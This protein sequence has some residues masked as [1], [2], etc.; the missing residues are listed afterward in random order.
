[1]LKGKRV[2]D[3]GCGIGRD[4]EYLM[5]DGF[6]VIG[7]DASRNM[8]A[9]AKKNVPKGKFKIM[10]F[11]KMSFKDNSFDGI[12]AMHS[13]DHISKKEI[14]KVLKELAR[15]LEKGGVL[16]LAVYE[17]MGEL[18]VKKAEYMDEARH[19]YLYR[20]KEMRGCLE[21]AGFDVSNS[22]VSNTETNKWLEVFARKK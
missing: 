12:W 15:V 6:D 3:A 4:V 18:E 20:E 13:L 19:F 11:R 16:Y 10:D 14:V 21:E 2:L 5:E 1:M 9:E 7:I 22:D 17:G 8:V